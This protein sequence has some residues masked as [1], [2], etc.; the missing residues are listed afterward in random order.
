LI[1]PIPPPQGQTLEARQWVAEQLDLPYHDDMQEWPWE[2]ADSE[3]I[4]DYVQLYNW[5]ADAERVVIMEMLLQAATMQPDPDKLRLD[6]EKIEVLLTQN[7]H[8]HAYTAQYWCIW[9]RSEQD[10]N[11][12]HP[13]VSPYVRVWWVANYPIPNGW[14]TY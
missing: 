3:C 4:E 9:D 6:W 11:R 14:P 8:L 7:A 12:Y 5:A 10:F 2:V 13:R 1:K